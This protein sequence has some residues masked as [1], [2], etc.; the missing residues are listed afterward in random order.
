[1]RGNLYRIGV[2]FPADEGNDIMID[3]TVFVPDQE[4]QESWG[5]HPGYIGLEGCLERMRYAVDPGN[6]QFYFGPL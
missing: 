6:D 3:A 2:V 5:E 4:W 1:M